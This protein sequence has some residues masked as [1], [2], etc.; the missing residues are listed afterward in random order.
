MK[1]LGMAFA[2]MLLVVGTAHAECTADT[3]ERGGYDITCDH[4]AALFI[5]SLNDRDGYD[6]WGHGERYVVLPDTK[7]SYDLY[8]QDGQK[9][10][11]RS[12]EAPGPGTSRDL[13]M[14]FRVFSYRPT[15][16]HSEVAVAR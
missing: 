12:D 9:L 16:A 5:A 2:L 11:P 10:W 3:N 13:Y 1:T 15:A 6:I 8:G 7:G 4:G 14:M